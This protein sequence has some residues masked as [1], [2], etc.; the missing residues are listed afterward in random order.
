M[1]KFAAIF[2]F[3]VV[4]IKSSSQEEFVEPS[5][6]LTRF[7]FVQFTGGVVLIKAQLASFPD[8]LNFIFDTGSGGVSL[9]STTVA[10]L[11]LKPTPSERL[12]R[13]IAGIKKVGFL[14][15][16]RLRVPNLLIDSLSFHVNDY[17]ILTNVYGERIDGIIGYSVL[18]RY[19]IKLDYD[20]SIIEFWSK[21]SFKYPR[22]GFLLKPLITSIPV[23]AARIKDERTVNSRF[24]FDIGAGM[25]MI[26][27]NDFLKDS[28]LLSRKR[29]LYPK[30]AEGLGGEI[31]MTVTVIKEV[32]LGPFRFRNVPI[33]AFDDTY[34]VTSY[35]YLAGIIG[36][37]LLRRFNIILNYE[38]RDIYIT[39]NSHYSD[40]FD[41]A[42]TGIE[43]FYLDN[44]VVIGDVAKDSPAEKAGLKEGDLVLAVNR[45]FSQSLQQYKAALQSG[46]QK[47]KLIV[48]RNNQMLELEMKPKSILKGR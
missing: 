40:P 10:R 12:I 29:K 46:V 13:G 20:S 1:K 17:Q 16:Q 8:S 21:G 19:I 27:S 14:N 47:M 25:N 43:L 31:E 44:K 18:S 33:Y 24:L 2:C 9:D 7:R 30:L 35:P 3:L 45:N 4:V 39:P 38:K 6:L 28:A 23:Q 26:L 48:M 36:N 15:Y 42:Y 11:G 32:K 34:N 37:D 5:K 22:G 41:Y